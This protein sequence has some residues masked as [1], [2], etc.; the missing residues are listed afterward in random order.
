M[1]YYLV[2]AH[3]SVAYESSVKPIWV[4]FSMAF[5][6]VKKVP[7]VGSGSSNGYYEGAL[8]DDVWQD[9]KMGLIS[10]TLTF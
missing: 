9:S 7:P 6:H 3:L 8:T 4:M 1:T 10:G 2:H 5:K